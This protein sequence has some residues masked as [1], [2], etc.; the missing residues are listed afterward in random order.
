[1]REFLY[2]EI[3]VFHG[4]SNMPHDPNRAITN[5]RVLARTILDPLVETFGPIAIRS[6]YRSPEVN[7]F[8]SEHDLGCASNAKN[9]AAHIWDHVDSAGNNGAS[10]SVVIPWF[11]SRFE[12]GR[13]W[14]DLAW[15]LHDHLPYNSI[16]F[17]PKR[18]AFNIGWRENPK[19]EI[20]SF[21]DPAGTLLKAGSEPVLDISARKAC[22]A[23]FPPFRGIPMPV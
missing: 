2:S 23:D 20:N 19:R 18:A 9:F 16:Q 22:Y 15:W 13:D 3:A 14:R 10:V 4:L 12:Q 5:G 7:S 6:A 11:A 1:M 21:L 8:G 17:F